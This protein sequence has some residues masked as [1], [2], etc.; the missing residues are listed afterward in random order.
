MGTAT[1]DIT[2][3]NFKSFVDKDGIVLIDWWAPWC[4]PCRAFGPVYDKV[5]AA[6]TDITFGKV[7]TEDQQALAGEFEIQSI[8][9]LMVFRDRVLLFSQAGMLPQ[10]ALEDLIK[11]VRSLDMDE[12]RREIAA[13]KLAQPQ[14]VA[15]T[16]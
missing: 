4:G 16:P 11:Q 12:V 10:T 2:A 1:V 5:A 13:A 7:N 3:T 9:T 6:N 15:A 8:P 14:A